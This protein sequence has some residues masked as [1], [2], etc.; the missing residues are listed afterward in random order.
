MALLEAVLV[1]KPVGIG[2]EGGIPIGVTGDP[3]VL[4]LIRERLLSSACAEAERW[5]TLDAGV[6]VL[7]LAEAERL[8][9]VLRLLLPDEDLRPRLQVLRR[10][11]GEVSRGQPPT[12]PEALT[13]V[14]AS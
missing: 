6:Y 9:R 4:R 2:S 10:T 5:Q 12:P 13:S 8:G 3:S 11:T 7:K 14:S 1:Y